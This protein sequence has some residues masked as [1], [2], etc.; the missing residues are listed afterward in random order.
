MLLYILQKSTCHRIGMADRLNINE[1]FF[2][3]A[4]VGKYEHLLLNTQHIGLI[5]ITQKHDLDII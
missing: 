2:C 4:N 3:S 5:K 1:I